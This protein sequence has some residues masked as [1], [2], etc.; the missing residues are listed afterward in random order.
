MPNRI[1]REGILTSDRVNRL[2][3][4][5]ELFYRRLM[6]VVDDFG[7]FDARPSVLRVSC[8]PLKV[9]SIREADISRS[10][11]EAQSAGLIALYE[12]DGKRFLQMLDFRQQMR[13][14]TSKYPQPPST[15]AADATHTP[16]DAQH[17]RS[18]AEA[19]ADEIDRD[20]ARARERGDGEDLPPPADQTPT[21]EEV[22]AAAT[23]AGIPADHATQFF[24]AC[25]ARPFA[26]S[27]GWTSKDGRPMNMERWRN[28][29]AAYSAS[30]ARSAATRP[31]GAGGAKR[32]AAPS[33]WDDEF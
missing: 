18:E 20:S 2:G 25:E 9:D 19:E 15:C 14:K 10:L 4:A 33:K 22:I 7:R 32:A 5:A 11:A 31:A 1:L 29:M 13:A 27:G 23:L 30:M 21:L 28:A 12:V 17:M 26:P 16:A 6:S 24:N 8:Y 3:P